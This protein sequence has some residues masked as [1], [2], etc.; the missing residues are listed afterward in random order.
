MFDV[1][2]PQMRSNP[3]PIYADFR[4]DQPLAQVTHPLVGRAWLL[5]RYD[6]V[7]AVLKDTRFSNEPDKVGRGFKI[8]DAWWMPHSFKQTQ[9][10]MLLMDDPD[11]R[12]VRDL[13]HLA[14]TPR[15]IEG[16]AGRIEVITGELLEKM[17]KQR[18]PDLVR[19]FALPLPVTVIS[20][21]MGVPPHLRERFQR[22]S[23]STLDVSRPPMKLHMMLQV[24]TIMR[25]MNFFNDLAELRRREPGDDLVS[26]LVSVEQD[27]QRL[28]QD[29]L[30]GMIFLLLVAG[31]ETTVSLL[32]GGMLALF[33]HP[34][35]LARLRAEP[36]LIDS[37]IEELLRYTTPVDIGTARFALEAVEMHGQ[38]I[39]PRSVCLL[40][41]G[42]ANRDESVFP[43]PDRLDLARTPNRHLGFGMGL[44]YCLGA[45]LA[46]LEAHIALPALLARFPNLRRDPAQPIEWRPSIA[47]RG[48]KRLAV[49]PG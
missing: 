13:V 25:L 8:V 6:D 40:A 5:T 20:E 35:Q 39:A 42:A 15:M 7:S 29:E 19:D 32:S 4:R 1:L 18:Q 26:A 36:T 9:R 2:A 12:R 38:V 44:H 34:D 46:R 33:E 24:P 21:I 27:G 41:L 14:F 37:A 10:N 3:F 23:N 11:H 48:L 28:S 17:A 31:H 22:W 16:M 43:D 45:P 30:I 47:V 49:L